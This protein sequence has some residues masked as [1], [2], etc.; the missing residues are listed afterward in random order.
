[1]DVSRYDRLVL[2]ATLAIQ[3]LTGMAFGFSILWLPL[4]ATLQVAGAGAIGGLALGL[5]FVSPVIARLKVLPRRRM[6]TTVAIAAFVGGAIAG[7]PLANQG[8]G[9][10]PYVVLAAIVVIGAIA[11]AFRDGASGTTRPTSRI[12]RPCATRKFWLL[13]LVLFFMMAAA[14]GLIGIAWPMHEDVFGAAATSASQFALVISLCNIGG[15]FAW[16][17]LADRIGRKTVLIAILTIGVAA[18]ALTPAAARLGNDAAFVLAL[19]VIV[20]I[21]GGVFATMPAYLADIFGSGSA[22]AVYLRLLTTWP[23]AAM[24]APSVMRYLRDKQR[25][26]GVPWPIAYDITLY[27]L[28]AVLL[29]AFIANAFVRPAAADSGAGS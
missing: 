13:W 23:A 16:A 27:F 12:R 6:A 28:A 25:L 26:I 9:R 7:G 21:G 14:I 11:I 18:C 5:G 22:G 1:M 17:S 20:S 19:G 3:F 15:Q 2:P 10:Q 4:A 8:I 24:A 29:L